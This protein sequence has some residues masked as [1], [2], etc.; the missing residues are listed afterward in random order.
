MFE[1]RFTQMRVFQRKCFRL[2]HRIIKHLNQTMKFE[3]LSKSRIL[4]ALVS[5]TFKELL[6]K[7][8]RMDLQLIMFPLFF[9]NKCIA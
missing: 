2:I 7:T 3:F 5:L 6:E 4:R 9:L 1:K 8:N